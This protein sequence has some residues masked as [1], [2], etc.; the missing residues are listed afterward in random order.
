MTLERKDGKPIS[1]WDFKDDCELND[2]IC[3]YHPDFTNYRGSP[4]DFWDLMKDPPFEVPGVSFQFMP[5]FSN[6][7]GI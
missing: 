3:G 1:I 4:F 5:S 6:G 7:G 2:A